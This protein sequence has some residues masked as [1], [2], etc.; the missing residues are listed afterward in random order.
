MMRVRGSFRLDCVAKSLPAAALEAL[1]RALAGETL[2]SPGEA[3]RVERSLPHGHVQAAL[4]MAGE[5]GLARLVDREPSPERGRVLAMIVQ[6]VLKPGSKLDCTRALARSSLAEELGV[7]GVDADELYAAMDWLILRQGRIEAALARRHLKEGTLVLYDVSCSYFE[8][9]S[10]PLAARGY[11]RDGRPGSLQIIYGLLLEP[12]GRPVALA[13][14]GGDRSR[15]S[16]R[17]GFRAA[18]PRARGPRVGRGTRPAPFARAVGND[19]WSSPS[20]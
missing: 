2:V 13:L 5:I 6:R 4:L 16:P 18:I 14:L 10:C 7:E 11:T 17:R 8:G 12:Q 1:R 20:A 15:A 19:G 9:R 3:F